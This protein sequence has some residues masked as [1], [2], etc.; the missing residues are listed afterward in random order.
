M[1]IMGAMTPREDRS[2][3]EGRERRGTEKIRKKSKKGGKKGDANLLN[4]MRLATCSAHYLTLFN[5]HAN[6]G[7]KNSSLILL[8]KYNYETWN[9]SSLLSKFI[10]KS[11]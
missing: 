2:M 3:Q 9:F 4:C 5:K 11:L 1:G 10:E 6:F 7:H 8:I